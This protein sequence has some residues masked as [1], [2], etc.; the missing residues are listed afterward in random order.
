MTDTLSDLIDA[1]GQDVIATA[2]DF[3][4][5]VVARQAAEWQDARTYPLEAVREACRAGLAEI[6]LAKAYGGMELG[7]ATKLRAFEAIAAHDFAFAFALINQH[8]ATTRIARDMAGRGVE[9][10]I[11][12]MRRGEKIGCPA[13]TEPGAGS[14]FAAIKTRATKDGDG[15]RL[16]GAKAWITNAAVCDVAICYAQ[17]DPDSGWRG[18]AAFLVR[19]DRPGFV[20]EAP[21]DITGG[22]A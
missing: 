4:H 10:L 1:K 13:L 18:I 3:A 20:R 2:H 21:F 14:D 22:M 9:E 8:N 19:A 5:R 11:A 12:Q 15:W 17:T 16:N 6:E 7:F